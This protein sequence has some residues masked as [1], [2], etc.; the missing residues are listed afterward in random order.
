[1]IFIIMA[2][3][4]LIKPAG[5]FARSDEVRLAWP[6]T[7]APRRS[8]ANGL[9]HQR[10]AFLVMLAFSSSRPSSPTDLP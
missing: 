9:A 3:C 4:S 7:P 6:P 5:L 8:R 1:V 10:T 2:I